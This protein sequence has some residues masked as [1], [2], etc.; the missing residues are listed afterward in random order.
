MCDAYSGAALVIAASMANNSNERCFSNEPSLRWH[1]DISLKLEHGQLLDVS[2][3][4]GH[5]HPTALWWPLRKRAW[6]FQEQVLA[7]R[8]LHFLHG[9]VCYQCTV[10]DTYQCGGGP[11]GDN[12]YRLKYR[13]GFSWWT[14]AQPYTG[15]DITFKSDKLPAIGGLAQSY[16]LAYPE[17]KGTYLAGLW[18]GTLLTDLCWTVPYGSDRRPKPKEWRAPS[19]TWVSCDGGG[20]LNVSR[21]KDPV[22]VKVLEANC[23]L[24]GANP[25]GELASG[26]LVLSSDV[27]LIEVSLRRHLKLGGGGQ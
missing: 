22:H 14:W 25:Y 19:W 9:E 11:L 4:K 1:Q 18:K 17:L 23:V 26:Y 27:E 20:V 10:T 24:E 16:E 2:I 21:L 6:V 13:D 5:P 15:L 7:Q 12:H 3:R 8:V